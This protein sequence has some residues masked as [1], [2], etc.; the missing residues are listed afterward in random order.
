MV[1]HEQYPHTIQVNWKTE[2]TKDEDSGDWI[3]GVD[4]NHTFDC[5][6]VPNGKA[7]KIAG[8]DGQ[9]IEYAFDVYMPKTDVEIPFG[10]DYTLNG[11]TKGTVKRAHNGQLNSRI[12]L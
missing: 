3:E 2:S 7:K 8:D 5:R 6:A 9:L 12:W 11:S 10:A 1:D 4:V